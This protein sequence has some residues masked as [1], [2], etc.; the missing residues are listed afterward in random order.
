MEKSYLSS[1]VH[2]PQIAIFIKVRCPCK[3]LLYTISIIP[4]LKFIPNTAQ[5]AMH[6]L[7][8]PSIHHRFRTAQ[9]ASGAYPRTQLSQDVILHVLAP[10][11][12]S[13][14]SRSSFH[15]VYMSMVALLASL[16]PG[17][18]L[19][20][21]ASAKSRHMP[22]E[23]VSNCSDLLGFVC[24]EGDGVRYMWLGSCRFRRAVRTSISAGRRFWWLRCGISGRV[25]RDGCGRLLG[26]LGI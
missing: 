18:R 5:N 6:S 14:L 20:G 1:P 15:S 9:P 2:F 12:I 10:S 11:P 26:G 7:Y 3:A 13:N 24:G 17:P 4:I 19:A 21:R 22:G 25:C 23:G 8:A 16:W